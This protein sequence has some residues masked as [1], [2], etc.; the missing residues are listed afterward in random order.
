MATTPRRLAVAINPSAAFGRSRDVGPR[1]CELL[2]AGGHEVDELVAGSYAE[3]AD[4]VREAV[5]GGPDALV[6]VGGDGMVGLG[7]ESVAGTPTALGLVPVGTGNDTA[8][9]LDIPSHDPSRAVGLLLESL[10]AGG[11]MI[12][13]GTAS[14]T[15]ER[16][17]EQRRFAGAVSCGFDALVNERA[18]RMRRPRGSSRYTIS[19]ALELARLTPIAYR[20]EHD[21]GV[22]ET[23]G[24]LVTVANNRFIG[25]GM[26]ITPEARIDDG[27]LDLFVVSRLTRIQFLRIFPK[28]FS[29]TH[30]GDPRVTILRTRRARVEAEDV[31]AYADGERLGP[32][33][34]DVA[35]EPGALRLLAP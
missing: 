24:M 18:N 4:R 28:V 26:E 29:G 23:E 17:A 14:W 5:A 31:V 35:V 1:V 33:P 12:D 8:R 3:L 15:G 9:G 2:R 32:L 22:L 20:I 34:V 19:I 10:E 11:R 13:V 6:V 21:G 7:A 27:L 30:V 25:G 16:G